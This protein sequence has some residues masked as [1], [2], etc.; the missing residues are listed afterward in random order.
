MFLQVSGSLQTFGS[1]PVRV[2]DADDLQHAE[3]FFAAAGDGG[4]FGQ[5]Q[6][7]FQPEFVTGFALIANFLPEADQSRA[8]C[9]VAVGLRRQYSGEE[10]NGIDTG[11]SD[12]D[13]LADYD[14]IEGLLLLVV[15]RVLFV[16]A[17]D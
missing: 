3:G 2:Q 15:V 5:S 4:S 13:S 17:P 10:S 16:V 1:P 11:S 9:R 8:G 7:S 14:D 12:D 6:G